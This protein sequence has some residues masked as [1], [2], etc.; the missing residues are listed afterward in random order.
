MVLGAIELE[1]INPYFNV[2]EFEESGTLNLVKDGKFNT[3]QKSPEVYV[4]NSI[5]GFER[6]FLLQAD[7]L[8]PSSQAELHL[9]EDYKMFDI[10]N[11]TD[12]YVIK[13]IYENIE[14]FRSLRN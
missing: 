3:N 5:I 6:G 1:S 2:V 12:Y 8:L 7:Q 9:M 14:N 10:D 4:L 13:N 11:L